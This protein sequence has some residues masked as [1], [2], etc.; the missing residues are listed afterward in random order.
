MSS[1]RAGPTGFNLYWLLKKLGCKVQTIAPS[2]IP[3][4]AG[5]KVKTDRRD[6]L[7]LAQLHRAD[8]LTAIERLGKAM[9]KLGEESEFSSFI[10]ALT[11][12]R[13]IKMVTATIIAAELGD[14]TRFK[15]PK[16]LGA[17]VGVVPK[18]HSSGNR[19]HRSG[20]T[21]TGNSF[22]RRILTEAAWNQ[23][24][25]PRNTRNYKETMAKFPDSISEL[26]WSA[27][28]RLFNKFDRLTKRGKASTL[29]VTAVV[30]EMLGFIWAIAREVKRLESGP[31][32]SSS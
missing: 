21:K 22:V 30:R 2:L 9:E 19:V 8:E 25:R 32:R 27:S 10:H 11:S 18:E 6:A 7:R 13:G 23:T 26:S 16:S 12:L 3:T 31:Q 24:R 1:T 5:D 4:R 28:T 15:S 20:I 29:A 14:V 17:F